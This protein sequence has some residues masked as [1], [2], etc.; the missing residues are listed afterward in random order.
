VDETWELY[1]TL[2]EKPR[3]VLTPKVRKWIADAHKHDVE[4]TRQAI[5]GLAAS[6][7]HRQNGYVG[8]EYAIKPKAG[9]TME[10]RLS[11][12]AAKAP[13]IRADGRTTVDE[14]LRTVP[15]DRHWMIRDRMSHV[16]QAVRRG[17]R[18]EQA[19]EELRKYPGVEPHFEGGVLKGW[20]KVTT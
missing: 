7:Y 15:S 12:M 18:D 1:A 19:E 13:A 10:G 8:I 5:R 11:M 16:I 2:M 6:D 20:K 17:E 9:E 4:M 14:L 3:A